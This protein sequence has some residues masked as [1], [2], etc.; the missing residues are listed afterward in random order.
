MDSI[1]HFESFGARLAA[2]GA[3][4]LAS[5][6]TTTV[7][8]CQAESPQALLLAVLAGATHIEAY[9]PFLLAERGIA[10]SLERPSAPVPVSGGSAA[11]SSSSSSGGGV[12]SPAVLPPLQELRD[13]AFRVDP[14]PLS[15]QCRCYVCQRHS[16]AYLHHLLT[17]QEMNA[18]ILLA[19]HNLT[20]VVDALRVCRTAGGRAYAMDLLRALF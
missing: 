8:F 16:R 10:L 9:F 20:Q 12:A 13:P 3:Y 19:L 5:L 17:V 11:S 6:T 1:N 2:L 4:A 15:H 14:R 18:T 7:V